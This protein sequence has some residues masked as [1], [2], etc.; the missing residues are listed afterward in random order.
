MRAPDVG[1]FL[2][3]DRAAP[4]DA[5]VPA[6]DADLHGARARG[7]GHHGPRLAAV[8]LVRRGAD[9][10]DPAG[11][12]ARADRADGAAL[13]PDRGADDDLDDAAAPTTTCPTGRWPPSGSPRPDA[14]P[15]WSRWRSS[16]TRVVTCLPV[17]RGEIGIR[18]SLVMAGYYKD[19]EATAEAFRHGWH[20]TGDIGYL[21]ADNFLFIVDRAK[22][23][24]ITG[25]FNVYSTEVEQALM[26]HPDIQDCAVIGRPDEKW[27]ERVVAVVQPHAGHEVDAEEVKTFVKGRIGA[28]K[29]PKEVH[30]GP[31]CR[32]PRS[33]R[34]SRTRS[35]PSSEDRR[36]T[37]GGPLGS[38]H[39]PDRD[40]PA[41]RCA[42]RRPRRVWRRVRAQERARP[43]P[44]GQ[45]RGSRHRLGAGDVAALRHGR[46]RPAGS[47]RGR[48]VADVV[49]VRRDA[50]RARP[51]GQ[52]W[53][54]VLLRRSPSHTSEGRSGRCRGLS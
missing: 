7:A 32:A 19:P 10:G 46:L 48:V 43:G 51:G 24:I 13:R 2:G 14:R 1:A 18:S 5:H 39:A 30:S 27:G 8:L 25:G 12:G 31:T 20:H 44:T 34:C 33:A 23:M 29:T 40:L 49:R 50:A 9:V 53:S 11:R 54:A 16:T 47:D 22:D 26:A 38:A 45:L 21:D 42:G 6:A 37:R 36:W 41:D 3:A 17:E 4:G 15:R 28:V 35:R 52:R